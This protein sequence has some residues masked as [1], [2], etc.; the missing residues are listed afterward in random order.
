MTDIKTAII[1]KLDSLTPEQQSALLFDLNAIAAGVEF[2]NQELHQAM[3]RNAVL[4]DRLRQQKEQNSILSYRVRQMEEEKNARDAANS[5]IS[6][7]AHKL[8]YRG[9]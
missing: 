1:R 9:S 6:Q 3:A 5:L 7:P 2:C 4:S 8:L